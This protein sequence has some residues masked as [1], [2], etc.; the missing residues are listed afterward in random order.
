M[1]KP[2]TKAGNLDLKAQLAQMQ[3]R[4]PVENEA[5]T[6]RQ[7]V[8]TPAVKPEAA[9]KP[10][11]APKK[12]PKMVV[13]TG[14]GP[15]RVTVATDEQDLSTIREIE[16]WLMGQGI[17]PPGISGLFR[18]G[19]MVA[20]ENRERLLEELGALKQRDRRRSKTNGTT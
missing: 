20:N 15:N 3:T 9:A 17:R 18:A 7:P 14:S 4:P 19:L 13:S 5:E 8:A 16:M 2:S 6:A 12:A 10:Q 11:K 1:K